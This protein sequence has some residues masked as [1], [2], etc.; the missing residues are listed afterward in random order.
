MGFTDVVSIFLDEVPLDLGGAEIY[1]PT[2]QGSVLSH[3]VY[4][5]P[6]VDTAAILKH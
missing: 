5:I 4:H 2:I 1:A 3:R 6:T